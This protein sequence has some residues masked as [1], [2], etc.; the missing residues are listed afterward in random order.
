VNPRGLAVLALALCIVMAV[1]S[2]VLIV[3][4]PGEEVDGDV[5]GG[6]GGIGFLVMALACASVG[7]IVARR[8][9]GNRIGWLFCSVGLAYCLTVLSYEY[10]NYGLHA[11][12]DLPGLTLA[13]WWP[14]EWTAALPAL[15]LLLFPHGRLA[16]SRWRPA[17]GVLLLAAVLLWIGQALRPGPF[18]DPFSTVSNPI[19][20]GSR[21]LMQAIHAAGWGLVVLGSGLA[22]ASLLARL[23]RSGGIERQQLKLVAAVGAAVAVI[24]AALM[25]TWLV[26]SESALQV[27]IGLMGLTF[28]AFPI[29]AGVAILRYR[30]YDIDVVINRT[31]V[32]A[33]LTAL[34][35]AAYVLTA[36]ALGAVAGSGSA[37]TTA[38]ATLAAAIAFRPLR[39]RVQDAVDRRFNRARYDA[40]RRIHA[41]LEDLRAGRTEPEAIEPLLRELVADPQLEL[42][43]F[44]PESGLYVDAQGR[45][46]EPGDGRRRTPIER[47]GAPIGLVLHQ[48]VQAEEPD[49]L[50]A[51]VEASG[52]AIEIARLR[53]GLRRQLA[54]VEASRA[55]I[56]LAEYEER[57]RIERDLHDG[58]QQRL[59][60]IGLALRHAQHELGGD[61]DAASVTLDG[62]VAE[63]A[64][65]IDELRELARGLPPAQLDA[66]LGPA[67]RELAGRS[68]L[69]VRIET[70]EQRLPRSVE[71]A[72]YFVACE[73]LTNAVKH[74][75]ASY[76]VLSAQRR[77]GRLVVLVADDGIGGAEARGGTGLRGLSDRVIAQG[78]TFRIESLPGCGTTLT[79][80]LPCVS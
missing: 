20:V 23:R 18:D 43:F 33:A 55:R 58:A 2:T 72:A 30:L 66:G 5:F 69:P 24:T 80:E 12:P 22:A 74:A 50:P 25:S 60:S 56:V 6:F 79:A 78:G 45:P 9:P 44:L 70:P 46:D 40:T 10:A 64:R 11:D 8:A 21:G 17:A 52:L 71:A 29:A 1:L 27:R 51:L 14:S 34:L 35:G 31:L 13:A 68:P 16:T 28:A 76:V 75:D 53:V 4:G 37:W 63:L 38:G 39:S 41:F 54:E 67:L 73:G 65:A 7:A 49:A 36:I 48:P 47:A 59:V 42:R 15:V 32:Y 26:S 61:A 77:N 19:G 3:A 57:R 62:A